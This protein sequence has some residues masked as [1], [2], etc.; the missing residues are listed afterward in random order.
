MIPISH[1]LEAVQPLRKRDSAVP[2]TAAECCDKVQA[3][4]QEYASSGESD[5]G[6]LLDVK[7][8]ANRALAAGGDDDKVRMC[9]AELALCDVARLT[10]SDWRQV[11]GMY[12]GLLAKFPSHA[13]ARHNLA[14]LYLTWNPAKAVPQFVMAGRLAPQQARH[15][16]GLAR[17]YLKL[18]EYGLAG[19][20]VERAK[21]KEPE[22]PD[23]SPLQD[24]VSRR[25][26]APV[27]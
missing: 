12:E 26:W 1:E 24:E 20:A 9:E 13:S 18:H 25:G 5:T 4:L 16:I 11:E 3:L 17:A 19:A 27:F 15:E 2:L 6:L 22:N 10:H 23:I 14:L 8:Y 7:Q 21:R